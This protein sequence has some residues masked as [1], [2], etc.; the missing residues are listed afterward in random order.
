MCHRLLDQEFW[1]HL[2][3]AFRNCRTCCL[4]GLCALTK[5][6]FFWMSYM[7]HLH[8]FICTVARSWDQYFRFLY[9]SFPLQRI[10]YLTLR[11]GW[12]ISTRARIAVFGSQ[13]CNFHFSSSTSEAK[14]F[15]FFLGFVKDGLFF[16]CSRRRCAWESRMVWAVTIW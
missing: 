15:P 4:R 7:F 2:F 8:I 16:V 11:R 5:N 13:S 14:T 6:S 9:F 1:S 10:G 12:F 3:W